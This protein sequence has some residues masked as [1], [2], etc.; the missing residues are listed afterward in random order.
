MEKKVIPGLRQEMY[1]RSLELTV[2]LES[3]TTIYIY[4]SPKTKKTT[5]ITWKELKNQTENSEQSIVKMRP[6]EYQLMLKT[7]TD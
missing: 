4:K 5:S 1:K 6:F 7:V 3:K 2:I